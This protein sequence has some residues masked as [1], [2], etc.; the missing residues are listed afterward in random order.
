MVMPTMQAA[1]GMMGLLQVHFRLTLPA[2]TFG[3]DRS[4]RVDI[5]F[6]SSDLTAEL[7]YTPSKLR[8][9]KTLFDWGGP[10]NHHLIVNGE[11]AIDFF[12]FL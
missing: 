12:R 8:T 6:N 10:D 5:P 11:G 3:T 1:M 9:W 4:G 7:Q 2:L